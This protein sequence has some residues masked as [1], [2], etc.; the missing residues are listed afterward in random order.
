MM[1]VHRDR[2]GFLAASSH[3]PRTGRPRLVFT[4]L[5]LLMGIIPACSAAS[6]P[7]LGGE[8]EMT[9]SLFYLED[10][11]PDDESDV[12]PGWEYDVSAVVRPVLA[13]GG[14]VFSFRG[15]VDVSYELSSSRVVPALPTLQLDVY[16]SPNTLVRAGR[17]LYAPGTAEFFSPSNRFLRS[18]FQALLEGDLESYQVPAELI[19]GTAF[20]GDFFIRATVS[21]TR[22][23]IALPDVDSPW[24]PRR[25][26][27]ESIPWVLPPFEK[28]LRDVFVVET[29]EPSP[30]LEDTSVEVAAG[31]TILGADILHTVFDGWASEAPLHYELTFAPG[32]V[33]DV[34]V[35]A[36]MKR[37]QAVG[38]SV[39]APFGPVRAWIDSAFVAGRPY[40]SQYLTADTFQTQV[41]QIDTWRF[42]GGASVELVSLN[43]ILLCEA[44]TSL[45]T[46]EKPPGLV[47]PPLSRAVAASSQVHLFDYRLVLGLTAIVD[48][49]P[50]EPVGAVVA[51]S[52]EF[53]PSPALS[54]ALSAP[55]FVGA[56]DSFL[57]QYLRL[58]TPQL[59]ATV[60]F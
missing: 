47:L 16:P 30:R 9:H 19:Q 56:G 6:Q 27:P 57:G 2:S 5:M 58:R 43:T 59:S 4:I 44:T 49:T 31:G 17:F 50:D 45:L 37:I 14:E 29:D 41:L 42:T 33:Y 32:E 25:D 13:V 52:I 10:I 36:A 26:I 8:V 38:W 22:G 60:R 35:S 51:T 34:Y 15:A 24:F 40:Q 55:R 23:G 20:V 18:D 53:S 1:R 46:Q 48:V 12:R 21:P 7:V 11:H 54:L 39:V 28:T 3:E